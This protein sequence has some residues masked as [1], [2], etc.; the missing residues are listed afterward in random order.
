MESD[1]GQKAL[2]WR[3]FWYGSHLLRVLLLAIGYFNP[4]IPGHRNLFGRDGRT[5]TVD[6]KP[7]TLLADAGRA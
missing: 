6:D 3:T 7:R 1:Q 2:E 5:T 4:D